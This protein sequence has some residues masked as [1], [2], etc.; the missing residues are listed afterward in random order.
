VRRARFIA[1]NPSP[2]PPGREPYIVGKPNSIMF[3]SAM[4]QIDLHSETTAIIGD[5]MDTDTIAGM[6]AGLHTVL[7]LSGI[8]Q[9]DEIA[10]YP[11]RPNNPFLFTSRPRVAEKGLGNRDPWG[12][13]R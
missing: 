9:R 5:R 8:T 13:P 7:V 10:A 6:E 4:N 11:F 3:R 2:R 12:V 1:T